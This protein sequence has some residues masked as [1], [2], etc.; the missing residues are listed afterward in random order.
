MKQG[1]KIFLSLLIPLALG[2]QKNSDRDSSLT[3][4]LMLGAAGSQA[5]T[6]AS[7]G[8]IQ[9]A[10][11]SLTVP[12]GALEED[13]TIT[14]EKIDLPEGN[15]SVVPLQAGF[16]FGPEGLQ[17]NKPASMTICYDV[18]DVL[19]R[20]LQEK[21]LQIQHHNPDTGEFVSMGGD[22]DPVNH[23]VTAPVYHFSAY[24]LTAQLLAVANTGPTIGG[25]TFFPGTPI[26][27]LPVTVRSSVTD[28]DAASAIA[29]VRLYYRTAGSGLAFKSIAMQPEPNDPTGQFYTAKVPG[30]DVVAAGLEYY[31]EAYDSLNARSAS[32]ATA[33]AA[34]NTRTGDNPDGTTPIRFQTALTQ[35]SAGFS[36]D[37]T[38]QVK[39]SSAATFFPV[40]A[41][42]L[43]FAGGKG[44]TSRP[45][46]LG[47]RY[48]AQVI[49]SSFLQASYGSQSVSM[50]IN[51]YPGVMDRIEVRYNDAVLPDP[52]QVDGN[53]VTQ[54]DAAGYDSFNNFMFVQ[55]VFSASPGIGTFGDVANYGKF[56]AGNVFPDASGTISA[57]VG[58]Y[59]VT[60]N[61]LVHT[62][63]TL[64]Q[65]DVGLFDD[66][67]VFN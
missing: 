20:G 8:T 28:W 52:L 62:T 3:G 39:G 46:W 29:N 53:S 34:F 64:C 14:Y 25:A 61:I 23:C 6:P 38:V 40:P 36:R 13:T 35:M 66:V 30:I 4:F 5:I 65:F 43:T 67:C 22:V 15:E 47:A 51:V 27:G 12:Q 59:T 10:Q 31:I 42:T 2:C 55:P 48:T 21:T 57:T 60:Y 56:T 58:G 9:T 11:M 44:T 33:P 16:K 63:W 54:L 7:G 24:I 37:L 1:Q 18:Q 41:D 49:G 32:P 17:F 50:P 26:A 19:S 45:N